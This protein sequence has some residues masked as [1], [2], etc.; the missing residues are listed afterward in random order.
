MTKWILAGLALI[1]LLSGAAS[2]QETADDAEKAPGAKAEQAFDRNFDK[3]F[4]VELRGGLTKLDD[5]KADYRGDSGGASF[6]TGWLLGGAVGYALDLGWRFEIETVY[7]ENVNDDLDLP[8]GQED[9]EGEFSAFTVMLNVYY[10]IDLSKA[11]SETFETARFKP[12]VGAGF[13]LARIDFEGTA[14]SIGS[15]D[16]YDPVPAYQ[17]MVGFNYWITPQVSANLRF[18][19]LGTQDPGFEDAE[20]NE[21]E[22]EYVSKALMAGVR[23]R[24]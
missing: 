12:F 10:D 19:V 2:A 11:A 14:P 16:K 3:G 20:G 9:L 5:P 4:Y 17:F 21:L 7:R 18:A 23:Y 22:L 1:V 15:I 13:G 8:S 24:F 6:D